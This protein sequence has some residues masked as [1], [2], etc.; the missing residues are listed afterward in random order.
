MGSANGSPAGGFQPPANGVPPPGGGN[1]MLN[2]INQPPTDGGFGGSSPGLQLKTGVAP[3]MPG[4]TPGPQ[5]GGVM[6]QPGFNGNPFGPSNGIQGG[7]MGLQTGFQGQPI[8][9][10][11]GGLPPWDQFSYSP[12][13]GPIQRRPNWGLGGWNT[14]PGGPPPG[15]PPSAPP[16]SPPGPPGPLPPTLPGMPGQP[17][18]PG[19]N[20]IRPNPPFGGGYIPPRTPPPGYAPPGLPPGSPPPPITGGR[21]GMGGN[22]KMGQPAPGSNDA[23]MQAVLTGQGGGAFTP[24]QINQAGVGGQNYGNTLNYYQQNQ[25]QLNRQGPQYQ[26]GGMFYNQAIDG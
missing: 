23:L 20:G 13:A 7:Q 14:P 1:G 16:G 17:V 5:G 11:G 21:P 3:G 8:P 19:F 4:G 22:Q 10:T 25:A 2:G 12:N 18:D 26:P 24:G 6:S 15:Q 9:S